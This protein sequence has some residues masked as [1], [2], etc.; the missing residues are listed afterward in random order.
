MDNFNMEL[1]PYWTDGDNYIYNGDCID[2]LGGLSAESVNMLVTDPPYNISQRGNKISRSNARIKSY[3]RSKDIN[4]DFGDWDHFTDV[5]YEEFIEQFV[6]LSK[7][8]LVDGA[9]GYVFFDKMRLGI[10]ERLYK[11]Y[12]LKYRTVISWCK[13]NPP[14]CFRKYNWVSAAEFIS[15]FSK[16]KGGIKRFLNPQKLMFNYIM[17]ANK[18]SYGVTKHPTEKPLE[19]IE[20]F[21]L[22]GTY[23]GDVVL[24]PFLGSGTTAVAAVK[25]NRRFVGIEQ[26]L[27]YCQMAVERIELNKQQLNLKGLTTE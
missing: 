26:S 22:T 20:R 16:G 10:L 15:V 2:I 1:H 5:E 8:A 4:L 27:E 23:E 6:K 14:P 13:T 19:I 11:E 7:R 12:E 17:T 3:R 24:D 25:N 21:I 18:T 9:W